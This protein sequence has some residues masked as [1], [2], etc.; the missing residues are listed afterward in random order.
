M[1]IVNTIKRSRDDLVKPKKKNYWQ[2]RMNID[3]MDIQDIIKKK[4]LPTVKRALRHELSGKEP[5]KQVIVLS[6][7]RKKL[8]RFTT[9]QIREILDDIGFNVDAIMSGSH[10]SDLTAVMNINGFLIPGWSR[11]A[12][13]F[14]KH[15]HLSRKLLLTKLSPGRERLHIRLFENNDGAWI[16]AAHT[17]YNWINLNPFKIFS[18]HVYKGNGD[19]ETGTLMMYELLRSFDWYIRKNK[20]FPP[21][22]IER[23]TRWAYY[24]TLAKR[25]KATF[26]LAL[27]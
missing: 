17:D 25:F 22:E 19:Y 1:G 6:N 16:I 14:A 8:G 21:E 23:I 7:K 18:A 15:L 2:Y 10:F 27:Y 9:Y 24:K 20:I 4:S 26:R 11:L 12:N 13:F 5:I 3:L